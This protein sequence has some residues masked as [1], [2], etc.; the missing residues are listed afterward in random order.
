MCDSINFPKTNTCLLWKGLHSSK[1]CLSL[2]LVANL[3]GPETVLN[4]YA[5]CRHCTS[6]QHAL[7]SS[8]TL[9]TQHMLRMD[10]LDSHKP[11]L[12]W[13]WS[14]AVCV[15]LCVCVCPSVCVCVCVYKYMFQLCSSSD[16]FSLLILIVVLWYV[17]GNR[18]E[19]TNLIRL[20]ACTDF[21]IYIYI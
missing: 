11:M 2:V 19:Y 16:L 21:G 1:L 17:F 10:T 12:L 14:L 3:F 13:V 6:E 9:S 4:V 18:S 20:T 7:R 15:C 5:C 8:L